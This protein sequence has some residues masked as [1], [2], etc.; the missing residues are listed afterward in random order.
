MN[1]AYSRICIYWFSGTGNALTVARWMAE[2]CEAAGYPTE[3]IPMVQDGAISLPSCASKTLIIFTFPTHGFCAPWLVLRYLWRFPAMAN[4]SVFFSNTRGAV[5]VPFFFMPGL[6]GLA[7]WWPVLLFWMRG[8]TIAG[9]LPVDMPHSWISF[10]PPNPVFGIDRLMAR[11]RNIVVGTISCLLQGERCHRWS[12]WLTLPLDI[13]IASIIPFYLMIGRFGLA[14]TLYTSPDCNNCGLCYKHCPVQ[15]IQLRDG[16]PYWGFNCENCMRCM[17]ICPKRSIQS[18]VTR[19]GLLTYLLMIGGM[20]LWH[21]PVSLW[22]LILTPAIFPIYRMLH[23]AL[24]NRLLN[25]CLTCTSLTRLWHRY[26]APGVRA[27]DFLS[28]R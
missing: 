6:S 22:L 28:S 18:W 3:L 11:A 23:W 7:L 4:A 13:A 27:K 24:G 16:R 1:L 8:Y 9:T 21:L 17:N 20:A 15:A 12:V 10:F 26:L 14:K 5:R 2:Y 19:M 25:W